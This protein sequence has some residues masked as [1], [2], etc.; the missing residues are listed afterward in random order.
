VCVPTQVAGQAA[1][2]CIPLVMEP[3]SRFYTSPVVVLDFQVHTTA[4]V[5]SH[6]Q[7]L[8]LV[9]LVATALS[10]NVHCCRLCSAFMS[11]VHYD[12]CTKHTAHSLRVHCAGT[13]H[14]RNCNVTLSVLLT[15]TL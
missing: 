15:R 4:H 14:T 3:R 11:D 8:T 6:L 10:V 7:L 1:M 2:E 12:C 9:S 13:S 5:T